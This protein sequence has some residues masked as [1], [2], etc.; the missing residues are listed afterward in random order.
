MREGGDRLAQLGEVQPIMF[1][2]DL[3]QLA[4]ACWSKQAVPAG[5]LPILRFDLGQDADELQASLAEI[6]PGF[7][8]ILME[9]IPF[10]GPSVGIE[11]R[12]VGVGLLEQGCQAGEVHFH[13]NISQMTQD[14]R[15]RPL[16]LFRPLLPAVCSQGRRSSRGKPRGRH[17][18]G[19][20]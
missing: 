15:R 8:A 18:A 5:P 6:I 20:G 16:A 10:P 9:I 17:A 19:P 14:L 4:Q 11:S 2:G 1:T 13:L 7:S 12:Q 3:H